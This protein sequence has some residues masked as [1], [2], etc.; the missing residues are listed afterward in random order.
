MPT[1][2]PT[3]VS[4]AV[5]TL[6]GE[7]IPD[8]YRWL[9]DGESAA[10]GQWTAAQ[11]ALTRSYLDA[12]P[13]RAAIHRRLD[14][15]LAIGAIS[16]PTP[17][18]GRYFYQRRDGR[19]NQPVL[20]VRLGVHGEDRALVDPNA[21]DPGGTIALDWHYP[22]D[23]GRLLAYGLSENGSERSVLHVLDVDTGADL[24]DRI[25]HTRAA[26]LAWLPDGTGFYYTHSNK[27]ENHIQEIQ[28]LFLLLA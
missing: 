6:H 2:P 19:Q 28:Y 25:P 26:D 5:E 11:N 10:T 18:K 22:S 9:E 21:L 14:E 13:G 3:P 4:D 8:P 23:D 12:V 24:G 17:A 27:T 1:Y 7:T 16:V 20:Y 15:L